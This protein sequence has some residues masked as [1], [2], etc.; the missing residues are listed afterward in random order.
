[1]FN[2]ILNMRQQIYVYHLYYPLDFTFLCQ[3]TTLLCNCNITVDVIHYTEKIFYPNYYCND[4]TLCFIIMLSFYNSNIKHERQSLTR[5]KAASLYHGKMTV[6]HILQC[7]I[8]LG[9]LKHHNLV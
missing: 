3:V 4:L 8:A 1:M 7:F 6:K 9:H 5:C 2:I